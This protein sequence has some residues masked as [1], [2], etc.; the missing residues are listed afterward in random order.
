MAKA[1]LPTNY[2][3]DKLSTSMSE[4]RRYVMEGN[5]DGTYSFTDVTDYQQIG[6]VWG[7]G[8]INAVNTAVNASVDANKIIDNLATLKA[9]TATGYIAGAK[10]VADWVKELKG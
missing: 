7:A 3:D 10:A 4:K 6:N 1:T 2:T 5:S 8:Q 9:V